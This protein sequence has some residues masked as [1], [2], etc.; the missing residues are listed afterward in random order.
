MRALR[1]QAAAWLLIVLGP[2]CLAQGTAT[3]TAELRQIAEQAY[4]FAYPLVVMHFT[5]QNMTMEGSANFVNHFTHAPFFPDEHFR[6]VVRPNADTL[7]STSWLDL[8]AEPVLLHVPDTHQRYYV[9]Q[10]MDAWSETFAAPGK[11]TT[12]TKEGWF[13]IAGPGWNGNLP[14]GVR[15]ID[16]PTNIVWLL[17]R[18]QTNG[19][20]DYDSVH[21]IQGGYQLALLSHF[22]DAQAPIGLFE[23]AAVRAR[24]AARPADQVERMSAVEFFSL[25]AELLKKNPP[26]KGDERMMEKLAKLGIKPGQPFQSEGLKAEQVKAIEEGARSASASLAGWEQKMP[27]GKTGWSLPLKVGRYG[28]DYTA[29]AITARYLLGAVPP[30]DAVYLGCH[31]DA[32]GRSLTG[33]QHYLMHFAK[34]QIPKVQAF[35]SLTLYDAQGYFAAN[36]IHRFAIGDRDPLKFNAD[37]SLDIYV[38]HDSPGPEK[39][40]NWLPAPADHFNLS[41]RMYW[42]D[43][44]IISG[45][46]VPPEITVVSASTGLR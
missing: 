26:H 35:W 33:S 25:F 30:E 12:G 37:G 18:T 46:W 9:M 34:N 8:A 44:S 43:E 16:A 19:A 5:R 14:S 32:Q 31:Q 6:Q 21:S 29:R 11:R 45:S 3:S 2:T 4:I 1:R 36:P 28:T 20:S 13:A 41:L 42:A 10:L 23:L 22:P 7:Y 27:L 40:S 17:G 24:A 39:E 38:Q 15:R